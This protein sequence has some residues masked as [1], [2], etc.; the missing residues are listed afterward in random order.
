VLPDHVQACQDWP[1]LAV[2]LTRAHAAGYNVAEG[3][4]RLAAEAAL[5][6]H[7]APVRRCTGGCSTTAAPQHHLT[8]GG[9]PRNRRTPPNMPAASTRRRRGLAPTPTGP[10]AR[11][12][13]SGRAG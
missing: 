5:P 10:S 12:A 6:E 4:P 3:L 9:M 11:T 1:R 13:E 8:C 2:A 7:T